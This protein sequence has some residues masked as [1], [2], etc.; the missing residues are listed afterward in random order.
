[1]ER[2]AAVHTMLIVEAV[3]LGQ[4]GGNP[5]RL[6]ERGEPIRPSHVSCRHKL[7]CS[8]PRAGFHA[9]EG[10]ASGPVLLLHFLPEALR[11]Q[12][13][14]AGRISP[15]TGCAALHSPGNPG[16]VKQGSPVGMGIA[17]TEKMDLELLYR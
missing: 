9:G 8:S 15:R 17:D 14:S 3:G 4:Y 10:P 1:M 11:S 13:F 5:G 16:L 7:S 12:D 2:L 6:A